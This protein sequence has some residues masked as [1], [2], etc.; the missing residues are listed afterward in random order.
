VKRRVTA[1][2]AGRICEAFM[3]G[4]SFLDLDRRFRLAKGSA[5]A[6]YRRWDKRI[7]KKKRR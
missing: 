7:T 5:E 6:V 3:R 4:E 1:F 2:V